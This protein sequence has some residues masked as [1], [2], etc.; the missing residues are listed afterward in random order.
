M[1][2]FAEVDGNTTTL[3]SIGIDTTQNY[4][5]GGKLVI[6]EEKIK[7][8][9]AEDPE[10]VI[11]LFTKQST[12]ISKAIIQMLHFRRKKRVKK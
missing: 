10:N 3:K 6:D 9:F 7:K 11:E 1:F 2:S 8:A 4:L 5:E 12:K